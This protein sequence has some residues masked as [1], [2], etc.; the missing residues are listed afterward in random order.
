MIPEILAAI[1]TATTVVSIITALIFV[2]E[3]PKI[4]EQYREN[5]KN[6][7]KFTKDDEYI[8]G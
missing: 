2:S 5:L 7:D 3:I 6:L 1:I 8:D 4:E